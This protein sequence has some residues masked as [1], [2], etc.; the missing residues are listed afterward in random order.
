MKEESVLRAR[1]VEVAR[2][3]LNTPFVD[4]QGLKHHGVDCAYFLVRVAEE[5]GLVGRIE[6]PAYSPQIYLHKLGDDT[7]ERI[8]RQYAREITES[9]VQAGDIVLYKV[10]KSYTHGGI[11]ASWPD[12]VIHPIRPHGVVCSS[13]NEGF[14]QGRA[15]RFFSAFGD[16]T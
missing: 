5:A 8:I 9:Q 7:Y 14:V 4:G 13:A 12:T 10:A 15:H 11:I 16:K 3:W 6:L 2:T 1:I